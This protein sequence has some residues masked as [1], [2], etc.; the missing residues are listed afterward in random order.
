MYPDCK[1][2]GISGNVRSVPV[3]MERKSI[4]FGGKLYLGDYAL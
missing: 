3:R 4:L 1:E 2:A